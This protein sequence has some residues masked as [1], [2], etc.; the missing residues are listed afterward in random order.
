MKN[1]PQ[2]ITNKNTIAQTKPIS[3]RRRLIRYLLIGLPLLFLLISLVVSLPL[4]QQ[5]LAEEDESMKQFAHM[6]L[7]PP[8]LNTILQKID[9]DDEKTLAQEL[10]NKEFTE[11]L[12]DDVFMPNLS[13]YGIWNASGTLLN[14]SINPSS[15]EELPTHSSTN[16]IAIQ[17]KYLND[18]YKKVTHHLSTK[19][20][21][22]QKSH[23]SGYLNTGNI[24]AKDAWR[25]YYA[26]QPKTGEMMVVAQPWSQR[27]DSLWLHVFEQMM[28]LFL[29]LP[30][31]VGLVI[32]AVHKGLKPINQIANT[33]KKRHANDLAPVDDAI[34]KELQPLTKA[35]NQLFL[36]VSASIDKE[37]RFTADASHELKSPITAIKLQANELQHSLMQGLSTTLNKDTTNKDRTN[38]LESIEAVQRIQR[39]ANRASHLVDQ[40]LTLT[41]L[42]D[43][44]TQHIEKQAINWV[45]VSNDALKSVS[46]TARENEVKLVR[47]INTQDDHDILPVSGNATLLTLLLRNLL[48]NAVRYGAGGDNVSN[49]TVELTLSQHG[50]MIRDHGNGIA[51]Q[52]LERIHERFFRPAGQTQTGSGLGLSIVERIAE[53]HGLQVAIDNHKDG[54]VNVLINAKA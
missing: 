2:T 50:I 11:T 23:K 42:T 29:S 16:Q 45:T 7:A 25:L 43:Q 28:W 38:T 4:Y 53:L 37:K 49:K 21:S 8:D 36:R 5:L 30:L 31:L 26:V 17:E 22:G 12:T 3:I 20:V 32:W 48:D 33:V 6:M 19:T 51:P 39:T 24:F 9:T 46:L 54:G 52:H 10:I 15:E 14:S 44:D 34:P 13:E 1:S 35:L 47:H 40:L 27:L 41:K 18:F